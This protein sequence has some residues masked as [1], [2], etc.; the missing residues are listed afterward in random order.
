[1]NN[2]FDT[3]RIKDPPRLTMLAWAAYA[4]IRRAKE[5]EEA[6]KAEGQKNE[7]RP[8]KRP[9]PNQGGA[10]VCGRE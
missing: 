8:T 4:A 3:K 9:R 1:M 7:A 5:A 2:D 10:D 6:R